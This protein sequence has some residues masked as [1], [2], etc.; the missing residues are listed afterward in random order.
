MA[1][2]ANVVDDKIYVI[3]G[4]PLAPYGVV[5]P[6]SSNYVY[7]PETDSWSEMAPIPVPVMGYASVVLEDETYIIRGT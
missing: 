5:N 7:N 6:V 1:I 4:Q 3:S 2:Q